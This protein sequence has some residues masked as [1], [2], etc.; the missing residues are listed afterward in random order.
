MMFADSY[1]SPLRGRESQ[2]G[3][4]ENEGG[5]RPNDEEPNV[6]ESAHLRHPR[7]EKLLMPSKAL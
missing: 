3:D 7:P 2:K 5:T 1:S 4:K 6:E